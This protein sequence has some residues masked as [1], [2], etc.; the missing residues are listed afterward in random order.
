MKRIFL[1]EEEAKTKWCQE[2]RVIVRG[3]YL[4]NNRGVDLITVDY[5]N[6]CIGENCMAWR[7]ADIN[8]I[9]GYCG[10][11]VEPS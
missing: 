11:A 10:K 7:W 1:T 6:N 5:N 2:T 4:L 3:N 8:N 9:L